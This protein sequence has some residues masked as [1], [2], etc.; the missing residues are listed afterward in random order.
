MPRNEINWNEKHRVYDHPDYGIL[1]QVSGGVVPGFLALDDFREGGQ[2][3]YDEA[4]LSE[5]DF[6][7]NLTNA[8]ISNL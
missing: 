3:Q 2:V 8:D 6:V 4:V 7:G 1:V 5:A